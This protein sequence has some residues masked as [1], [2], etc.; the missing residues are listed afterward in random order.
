VIKTSKSNC[1]EQKEVAFVP[2]CRLTVRRLNINSLNGKYNF[3]RLFYEPVRDRRTD[4]VTIS[5][6]F[7]PVHVRV[8]DVSLL[9]VGK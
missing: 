5:E 2:V 7:C 8:N 1:D 3:M 6:S 4:I 9:R